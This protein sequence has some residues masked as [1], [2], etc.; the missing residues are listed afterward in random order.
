MWN[1]RPARSTMS[2]L[3]TSVCST[4]S[5]GHIAFGCPR[6]NYM[7][8]SSRAS[9]SSESPWS[10]AIISGLSSRNLLML[11]QT[12]RLENST[13]QT[14]MRRWLRQKPIHSTWSGIW[15]AL[16]PRLC[17]THFAEKFYVQLQS[18]VANK[19][20]WF[21]VRSSATRNSGMGLAKTRNWQKIF[22]KNAHEQWT[23]NK[24]NIA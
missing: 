9:C 24:I 20:H 19:L 16:W 13:W 14:I 10:C 18:R 17:E 1:Q 21:V 12:G 2:S 5:M 23:K 11:C 8:C 4:P 22:S 3:E 15:N 7:I 6:Q